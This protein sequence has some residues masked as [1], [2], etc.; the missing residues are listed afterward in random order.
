MTEQKSGGNNSFKKCILLRLVEN[1]YCSYSYQD[2]EEVEVLCSPGVVS[3]LVLEFGV[4]VQRVQV[5]L[6]KLRNNKK[7][8]TSLNEITLNKTDSLL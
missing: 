3:T 6:T 1:F 7:G 8:R 4:P 2:T 5:L